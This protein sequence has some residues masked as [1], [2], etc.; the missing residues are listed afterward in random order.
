[1]DLTELVNLVT[2]RQYVVNSREFPSVD[3]VTS[4]YLSGAL[5]MIDKKIISLLQGPEFKEYINHKDV[6][7]AIDEVIKLNN[8]KSGMKK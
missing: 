5:I 8:I 3:T 7:Q 1:M 6:R 4:N 2:I